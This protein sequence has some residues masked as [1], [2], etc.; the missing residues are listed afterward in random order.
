MR[1]R[2]ARESEG[3]QLRFIASLHARC[4]GRERRSAGYGPLSNTE[5]VTWITALVPGSAWLMY[6]PS[7]SP[8]Q[9]RAMVTQRI[10]FLPMRTRRIGLVPTNSGKTTASLRV[11]MV[12]V[13]PSVRQRFAVIFLQAEQGLQ[14]PVN[15]STYRV[16][17]AEPGTGGRGPDGI[18]EWRLGCPSAADVRSW[19]TRRSGGCCPRL[20]GRSRF[21]S[22]RSQ[23]SAD[24]ARPPAGRF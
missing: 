19:T 1:A 18:A 24:D 11:H 17:T 16:G 22:T 14:A 20:F 23:G 8:L 7:S 9:D 4:E 5:S 21:C 15:P 2:P 3:S 10:E 6:S 12:R 13:T